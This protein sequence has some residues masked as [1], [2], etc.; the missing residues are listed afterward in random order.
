MS[1]YANI[2]FVSLEDKYTNGMGTLALAREFEV[3]RS[4]IQFHLK[5]L[6]VV[7]RRGQPKISI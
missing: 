3:S 4:T 6:G 7:L 5:R 1:R 2:D